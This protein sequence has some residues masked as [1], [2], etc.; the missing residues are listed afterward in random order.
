MKREVDGVTATML[1]RRL[2]ELE[3]HGFVDRAVE[4]TTPPTTTYRLTEEGAEVSRLLAELEELTHV[5]QCGD[6]SACDDGAA[7]ACIDVGVEGACVTLAE[8]S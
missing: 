3:C 8:C 1:S 4:E 7:G 6:R 2:K 5:A